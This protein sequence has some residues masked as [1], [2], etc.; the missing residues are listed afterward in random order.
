VRYG[1][2]GAPIPG[3]LLGG[4]LA[5]ADAI[6]LAALE[7]DFPPILAYAVAN[8]ETIRGQRAGLW[9]ASSV[10]SPDGGR[11]LFQLTSWAPDQWRMP[12]VNAHW[13]VVR[14]LAPSLTHY[15]IVH[16]KRGD[17]LIA[18]TADAF[19]SGAAAICALCEEGRNPDIATTGGN[20]GRDVT[21]CFHALLTTGIPT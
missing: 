13:A 7:L 12:Y 8:R 5:Y 19:N 14:W 21:A 16:R 4:G 3:G 6:T 17:D 2:S 15:A 10:L 9:N 1:I 20:Y 18:A 11:G